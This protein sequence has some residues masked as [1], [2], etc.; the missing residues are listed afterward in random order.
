MEILDQ[1]HFLYQRLLAEAK[2]FGLEINHKLSAPEKP[3]G[4][5]I[6]FQDSSLQTFIDAY[7]KDSRVELNSD[8]LRL[9]PKILLVAPGARL[10]LQ[11]HARR[12]EH[13][14]VLAG[15]VKVIIGPDGTSLRE[16]TLHTGE[17]IQIPVGY[18]HRIVGLNGWGVISELWG[19]IDP[20]SPSDEDDIVRVDDD[21]S[22]GNS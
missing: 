6:R 15:P 8:G 19:H 1:K 21:Y 2:G 20:N 22:R 13:W 4:A 16:Y 5:Y 11:Y 17:I 7:W 12:Q 3:W 18:W 14:R 10:S 9:A